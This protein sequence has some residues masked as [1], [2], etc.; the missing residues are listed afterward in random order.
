MTLQRLPQP[1]PRSQIAAAA[2]V[3]GRRPSK[4][5]DNIFTGVKIF[6]ALGPEDGGVQGVQVVEPH[7]GHAPRV[8]AQL[9][10]GHGVRLALLVH[11]PNL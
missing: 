7:G 11:V 1:P 4:Y 5:E 2:L 3:V 6:G 9:G 10:R 8:A